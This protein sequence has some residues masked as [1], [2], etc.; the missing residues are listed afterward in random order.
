MM[1]HASSNAFTTKSM[2]TKTPEKRSLKEALNAPEARDLIEDGKPKR[3]TEVPKPLLVQEEPRLVPQS[4]RLPEP[5]VDELI[6]V[7]ARRKRARQ[8]PWSHQDIVAEALREWFD[9]HKP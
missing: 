4:F 6:D 1:P 5:L 9:K 8:K 3:A 7:S 2:S